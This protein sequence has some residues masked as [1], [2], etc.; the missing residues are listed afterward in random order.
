MQ[1]SA[2]A[3]ESAVKSRMD[4]LNLTTEFANTAAP[5]QRFDRFRIAHRCKIKVQ[6]GLNKGA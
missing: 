5:V 6:Y 1:E 3:A 4:E 2:Q